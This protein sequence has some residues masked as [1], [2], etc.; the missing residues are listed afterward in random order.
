MPE[1]ESSPPSRRP[2]PLVLIRG[3][4][5][6]GVEDEKRSTEYG[7]RL[8]ILAQTLLPRFCNARLTLDAWHPKKLGAE[9]GSGA[10]PCFLNKSNIMQDLQAGPRA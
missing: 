5:G 7:V 10:R 1:K 4:G 8:A 3:F 9:P 2:L 6:L